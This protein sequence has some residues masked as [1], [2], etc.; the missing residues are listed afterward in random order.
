MTW[1]DVEAAPSGTNIAY[2]AMS[3]W[4]RCLQA[5]VVRGECDR[6]TWTADLSGIGLADLVPL[7]RLPPRALV[8]NY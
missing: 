3:T 2:R 1:K 6:V 5:V 7:L 8:D 4:R